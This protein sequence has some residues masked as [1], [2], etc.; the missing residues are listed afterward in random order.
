MYIKPCQPR[1]VKEFLAVVLYPGGVVWYWW[2]RKMIEACDVYGEV[3]KM[4][5]F[6]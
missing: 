1:E 6:S 3:Y 4:M 2:N 5:D